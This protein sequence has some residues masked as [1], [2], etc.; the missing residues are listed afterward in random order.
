MFFLAPA[1]IAIKYNM[2]VYFMNMWREKGFYKKEARLITEQA[3]KHSPEEIINKYV[4]FLEQAISDHP[5]SWLWSHKRWKRKR[6]TEE[7]S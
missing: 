5:E 4:Q 2:P 1:K 7:A 3:E 6:K